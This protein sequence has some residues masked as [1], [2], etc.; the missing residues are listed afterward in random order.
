MFQRFVSSDSLSRIDLKHLHEQVHRDIDHP[1]FPVTVNEQFS[2]RRG[3]HIGYVLDPSVH[4][5]QSVHHDFGSEEG[6]ALHEFAVLVEIRLLVEQRVSPRQDAHEDDAAGP[7]VQRRCLMNHLRQH[8]RRTESRCSWRER[9]PRA[10]R[11]L[12]DRAVTVRTLQMRDDADDQIRLFCLRTGWLALLQALCQLL[13]N[14]LLHLRQTEVDENSRAR[15]SRISTAY[16]ALRSLQKISRFYVSM[17][18]AFWMNLTH[19]LEEVSHV[20]LHLELMFYRKTNILKGTTPNEQVEIVRLDIWE[21]E[22][23]TIFL[24]RYSEQ[25]H[26]IGTIL[27]RRRQRRSTLSRYRDITSFT[28]FFELHVE[29]RRLIA[30]RQSLQSGRTHVYTSLKEP[31]PTNSLTTK[32]PM[33]VTSVDITA[34]SWITNHYTIKSAKRWEEKWKQ[35]K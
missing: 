28:I 8:L 7:D 23:Q 18:D 17:N 29:S 26:C 33:E 13:D 1:L 4:F 6:A 22:I 32:P 31:C 9:K 24:H 16:D 10:S 14:S 19:S 2:Q 15:L 30:K 3:L 21:N 11:V 35:R 27:S 5:G 34:N 25:R 20:T 12:A